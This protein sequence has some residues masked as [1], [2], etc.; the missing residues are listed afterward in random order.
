[1]TSDDSTGPNPYTRPG[2]LAAAAL[3]I[4]LA[5]VGVVL[6]I[7]SLTSDDPANATP[8]TSSAPEQSSAPSDSASPTRSSSVC[9]LAGE[10]LSG[11]VSVAPDSE[12]DFQGTTAFP[13]SPSYG[14]AD[15]TDEGIRMCFQRSPEGALFMAANAVVQGTTP[16]TGVAWGRY[17]LAEGPFREALL[18]DMTFS[19]ST[20]DARI[21]IVG[22]RVLDYEEDRARIDIAMRGTVAAGTVTMSSVFDLVW[23][24]GDWKVDTGIELPV[25]F[26]SIPDTAGY[27][28]WMG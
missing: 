3:V 17:A 13:T 14:P 19:D 28:P 25:T 24:D 21:S 1:M 8:S 4:I 12:W 18:A 20:E 23:T 10:S 2:F 27:T 16:E 22:F 11:T 6:G 15:S 5:V 26:S 7:L 9:G